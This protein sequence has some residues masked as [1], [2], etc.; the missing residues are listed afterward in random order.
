MEISKG[1]EAIGLSLWLPKAKLLAI[2]DLQLGSE[3]ALNRQGIFVPR[4]NYKG[5]TKELE[6]IFSEL[7]GKSIETILINGDIKHEFGAISRQE[8]HEVSGA[9]GLLKGKCKKAVLVRGNHDTALKPIAEAMDVLMVGYFAVP[10]EKAL[11]IHGDKEPDRKILSGV[12][13][14]IIGHE[15]PAITLND[16]V[17]HETYKCFLKGKYKGKELIVMPSMNPSAMGTDV[18]RGEI[19][20]P[21]IKDAGSFEVFAVE[22]KEI[23]SMGKLKN[24]E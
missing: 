2:T 16:G 14:I 7:E 23:F 13:K 17:K 5:I 8:W 15:H 19:L 12:K 22:S 21:L 20:S 4:V 10:E 24:L 9:I 6:K 1:I 11:F 18:S 3:E